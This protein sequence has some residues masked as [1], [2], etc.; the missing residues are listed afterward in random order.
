MYAAT[1]EDADPAHPSTWR[2]LILN[3]SYEPLHV[4]HWQRALKLVLLDKGEALAHYERH[5][6]ADQTSFPLPAV[7]RLHRRVPQHR[8][9]VRFSRAN[10]FARD[11]NTCQYCGARLPTAQLTY[12][13]VVPRTSGGKTHW[14]NIVACCVPCN[15]LK[16]G[17]TPEQAG[18]HLLRPPAR[19][20]W[21]PHAARANLHEHTPEAWRPFLWNT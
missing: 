9:R 10:V 20:E 7:I 13:H 5:V 21:I 17:R 4:V 1:D 18:M 8:L 11:Q 15:R 19:P 12:D 14:T 3:A 6:A 2:T 16:G